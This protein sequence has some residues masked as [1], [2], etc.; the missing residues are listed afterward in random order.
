MTTA[1]QPA[2]PILAIPVDAKT[3]QI[4]QECNL[5]KKLSK[6]VCLACMKSTLVQDSQNRAILY[7]AQLYRDIQIEVTNCTGFIPRAQP[8]AEGE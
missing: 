1:I 2:T 8:A 6:S 7:C 5:A 4:V 3:L